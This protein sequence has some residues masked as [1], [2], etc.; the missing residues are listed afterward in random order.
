MLEQLRKVIQ[1]REMLIVLVQKELKTRYKGS[2]LGFF[3]N[4]LNPLFMMIVYAVVFHFVS[5]GGMTNYPIYLLCGLIPWTWHANAVSMGTT[6]IAL[7]GPLINKIYFPTEIL[8]FVMVCANF[9]HF[10][11]G[12]ALFVVFIPF[13][14]Y[15]FS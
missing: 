14:G 15:G 11:F 3:W 7:N 5:R 8:P 12:M 4:I 6:T 1:Y 9:I 10:L 13:F 2:V